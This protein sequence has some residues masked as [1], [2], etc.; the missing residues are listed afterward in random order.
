MTTS[1]RVTATRWCKRGAAR[2]ALEI[3]ARCREEID[4]LITDVVMTGMSGI[5]LAEAVHERMSAVPVIVMTGY[6]DR[7]VELQSLPEGRLLFKPFS[8]TDLIN[9]VKD[10]L[11]QR[12]ERRGRESGGSGMS[13]PPG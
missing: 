7:Q 13:A 8:P 6:T 12:F 1:S 10:A 9:E 4:L 11:A 3:L 5:Q 2:E